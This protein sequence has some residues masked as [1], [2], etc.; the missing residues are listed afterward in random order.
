M[1]IMV[2]LKFEQIKLGVMSIFREDLKYEYISALKS[3]FIF[4]KK[5]RIQEVSWNDFKKCSLYV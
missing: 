4:T 2:C 5:G 3:M 1:D